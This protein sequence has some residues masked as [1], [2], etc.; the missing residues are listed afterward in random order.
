M[1]VIHPV[2]WLGPTRQ[3]GLKEYQEGDKSV[4]DT[5]KEKEYK[6][7]SREGDKSVHDTATVQL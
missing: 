3:R 7:I 2:S 5:D 1:A 6:R 4:N